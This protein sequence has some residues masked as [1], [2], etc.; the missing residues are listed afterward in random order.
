[1][2]NL[3]FFPRGHDFFGGEFGVQFGF[4]EVNLV[5]DLLFTA[6]TTPLRSHGYTLGVA[7]LP[8]TVTTRIVTFLVG[9]SY[10]PSFATGILG[11][12]HIQ[13]IQG[14]LVFL[15]FLPHAMDGENFHGRY[16]GF[17]PNTATGHNAG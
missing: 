3:C 13:D 14:I 4:P 11:G 17:C 5:L 2:R 12:G 10:K 6:L 16:I 8:V 15:F 1:M 7:P 9:D